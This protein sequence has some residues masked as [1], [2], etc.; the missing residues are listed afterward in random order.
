MAVGVAVTLPLAVALDVDE[1]VAALAEETAEEDD[2]AVPL[3]LPLAVG[4]ALPVAL[5]VDAAEP[6]AEDVAEPVADAVAD[7]LVTGGQ[8]ELW[9]HAP[10]DAIKEAAALDDTGTTTTAP[11]AQGGTL[12]PNEKVHRP[13]AFVPATKRD[14]IAGSGPCA[15]PDTPHAQIRLSAR[16]EP[17]PDAKRSPL[18]SRK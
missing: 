13:H 4:V 2:V 17:P 12:S 18:S 1:S 15:A 9:L 7:A 6:E 5:A 10:H 11:V 16:D 14:V 3:V 8:P